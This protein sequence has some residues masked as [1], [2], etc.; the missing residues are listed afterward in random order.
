MVE[1]VVYGFTLGAILYLFSIGLSLTFGTMKIINF[2]HGMAYTL[3]VYFFITFLRVIPGAFSISA[4]LA[5]LCMIPVAYIV[6]R[7]IIRRLYGES[8]DYAIIAT[9]A[10]LLI[11][12][13][14]I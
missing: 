13:D 12:T 11:G 6:E 10:V 1:S 4:L 8:L 5:V 7:L 14:F 9:Y 3:G 2:A